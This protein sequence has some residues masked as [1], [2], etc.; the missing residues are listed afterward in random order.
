LSSKT[1]RHAQQ[2]GSFPGAQRPAAKVATYKKEEV[3]RIFHG[4]ARI[5]FF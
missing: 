5:L 3:K 4:D 1:L 2:A